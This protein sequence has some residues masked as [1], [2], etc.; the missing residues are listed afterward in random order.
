MSDAD[1]T[2]TDLAAAFADAR[3][4]LVVGTGLSMSCSAGSPGAN[5]VGFLRQSIQWAKE[6]L[7]TADD[8][9]PTVEI[10][11]DTALKNSDTNMLISAASMISNKI[12]EIGEQA[13]LNWFAQTVGALP[14]IDSEW[15]N[16][17][18][19]LKCPILTTNYDTLI[20][21]AT[22]RKSAT[23][24]EPSEL[25][26]VMSRTSNHVGHLH[27]VW[28]QIDS[29]VLSEADYARVL[30][31]A[32][33]QALQQA[34]SSVTSLVYIGVGDGLDDPNF[35]K[36]LAWH[37]DTFRTSAVPHF[38][39]CRDSEL[40][41][42]TRNHGADNISA[43]SYGASW[44]DL[45]RFLEQF[46][47]IESAV[48]V[49]Q[50]HVEL[51]RD[52]LT[53]RVRDLSIVCE[54][55][56]D[57]E[58]RTFGQLIAPPVLLPLSTEQFRASQSSVPAADQLR[59][60][61]PHEVAANGGVTVIAGPD[62]SGRTTALYWLLEE[63][64]KTAL[65]SA[66]VMVEYS[67]LNRGGKPLSNALRNRVRESGAAM[68][69]GAPLPK[70]VVGIDDMSPFAVRIVEQ[71][72]EEL[73]A[74][75]K[76]DTPIFISCK[77][78]YEG[79]LAKLLTASGL[80]PTIRYVGELSR[81][82]IRD[83]VRLAEPSRSKVIEDNVVSILKQQHLP[84]TPF[85]VSLLI[86]VLN[87]GH[88]VAANS[89]HTTLLDLYLNQLIGRGDIAEDSRWGMDSD[90]R[91]AVLSDLAEFYIRSEAGSLPEA[92]VVDRI[93]EYFRDR[94]I[95]ESAADLLA[96]LRKRKVLSHE[97]GRI[98]FSHSSYLFVFAAKAATRDKK[99]R[100]H[101][102]ADPLLFAPILR[103]YPSLERSDSEFLSTLA[104]FFGSLDATV[105]NSGSIHEP[106]RK[107]DAPEDLEHRLGQLEKTDDHTGA[108]D[109]K[110]DNSDP[111]ADDLDAFPRNRS[112]GSP[113]ALPDDLPDFY[114][115]ST[116]LDVVSTAL[117][118]SLLIADPALK[119]TLLKQVLRGWG[120][121]G[122]L[123]ND[124]P[125]LV[126]AAKRTIEEASL[127]LDLTDQQRELFVTALTS[128]S[129]VIVISG[130]VASSLS[131]TRL[132][133]ALV[134][135][136]EDPELTH[137]ADS[138]LGVAVFLLD[139][140]PNGWVKLLD[141]VSSPHKDSKVVAHSIKLLCLAAHS[142]GSIAPDE[143]SRLRRYISDLEA[144]RLAFKKDQDRQRYRALFEQKVL[145][146]QEP[147][148]ALTAS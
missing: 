33:L 18:D 4:T 42:L 113:L 23:W 7:E 79:E 68:A 61:D 6:S 119:K 54:K 14:L 85:T 112:E 46:Y 19:R 147:S 127:A 76:S 100:A 134:D 70:L 21:Q 51:A 136:L 130:G 12:G 97:A 105:P 1:S 129:P 91:S 116:A 31:S 41:A 9:G 132:L 145:R 96:N 108:S 107:V 30:Q 102:L 120:K 20:E 83:L 57:L 101:L 2:M 77:E 22:G 98:H 16:S 131:T 135:A 15:A 121:L 123:F 104:T 88:V 87:A 32:P 110:V 5:W 65:G 80:Q 94:G 81:A 43:V 29:V 86:S 24:T 13:K 99:L 10:V 73:V 67:E 126:E 117:R 63:S 8:W 27:G 139:V 11:L 118:D 122:S 56:G 89:S 47:P 36:L 69:K 93:A 114:R 62:G 59:R 90:L 3:A 92:E 34:A 143:M 140:Q 124:D 144:R 95:P 60:C 53:A 75:S 66:P 50:N 78:G 146:Q 45:P 72:L 44:E 55:L 103:H 28:E 115:F 37:R 38:R 35:S 84:R 128:F 106:V 52:V 40:E 64:S 48:S 49:R 25:Q 141:E 142:T 39:L 111:L 133:A 58:D 26:K 82:D 74:L 17:L 148:K 138:A 125:E 71:T 137:D 109:L